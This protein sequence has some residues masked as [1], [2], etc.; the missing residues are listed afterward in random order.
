MR[1]YNRVVYRYRTAR[2]SNSIW[3]VTG[4]ICLVV[5]I[6][7]GA[8]LIANAIRDAKPVNKP[9]TNNAILPATYTQEHVTRSKDDSQEY[10]D[11]LKKLEHIQQTTTPS[12]VDTRWKEYMDELVRRQEADTRETIESQKA[13]QRF[14]EERWQANQERLQKII[15]D[16]KPPVQ[17]FE[18]AQEY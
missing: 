9:V 10:I 3:L 18:D 8:I 2:P 5:V 6:L 13:L 11:I 7:F 14:F 4:G 15:D 12:L 17:P 1:Q 16:A